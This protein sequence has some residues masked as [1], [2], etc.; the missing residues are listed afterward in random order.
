MPERE[1]VV[2]GTLWCGDC[3]RARQFLDEQSI[4]YRWVDIDQDGEA[5][6]LVRQLNHG[7]RSVP[8]LVFPDGSILVEPSTLQL[9]RRFGVGA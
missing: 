3:H 7:N 9:G 2:Y 4:V 5:A 8:T 6:A 1:L